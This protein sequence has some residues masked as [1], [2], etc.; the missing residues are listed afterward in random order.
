[1]ILFS[2]ALKERIKKRNIQVYSLHPGLILTNLLLEPLNKSFYFVGYLLYPLLWYFTKTAYQGSRT[3]T[4]L[5]KA[6]SE[7]LINGAYYEN[8]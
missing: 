7:K 2:T 1:M 6:K 4:F 5:A 3:T 8:L